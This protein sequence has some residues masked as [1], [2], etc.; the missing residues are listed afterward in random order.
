M[1]IALFAIVGCTP[2]EGERCNPLEIADIPN[3]GNCAIGFSCLYP[4]ALS[5]GVAYCCKVDST[6]KITDSNPNC[7]PDPTLVPVCKLDLGVAPAD[8]GG[9][10]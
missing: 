9:H 5:C 6:G 2:G 4:T 1:G 8:G 7:Q 3:Q 10:D